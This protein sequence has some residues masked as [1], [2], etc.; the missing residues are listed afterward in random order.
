MAGL[1]AIG[2][3]GPHLERATVGSRPASAEGTL[4]R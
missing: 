2:Q 4:A 3:L 1:M